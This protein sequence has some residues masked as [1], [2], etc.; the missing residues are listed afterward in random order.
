MPQRLLGE[1]KRQN[2][3]FAEETQ[4]TLTANPDVEYQIV[5]HVID[6][7]RRDKDGPLFPDVHFGVAR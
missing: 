7:L 4:V 1:S 2:E 5:V 6:S 3:R